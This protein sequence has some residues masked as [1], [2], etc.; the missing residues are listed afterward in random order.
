MLSSVNIECDQNHR[1][2]GAIISHGVWL[3]SLLLSHGPSEPHEGVDSYL[4]RRREKE[5]TLWR[6]HFP[7]IASVS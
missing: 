1:L 3:S 4:L 5:W 7:G 6:K 2:P